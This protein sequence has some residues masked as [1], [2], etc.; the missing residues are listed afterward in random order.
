[1]QSKPV[2]GVEMGYQSVNAPC[3]LLLMLPVPKWY[4]SVVTCR[5]KEIIG[6]YSVHSISSLHLTMAK[7]LAVTTRDP[8]LCGSAEREPSG[9]ECEKAAR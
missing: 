1:M 9:E 8:R 5:N 6:D 2:V 4:I 3:L 7:P